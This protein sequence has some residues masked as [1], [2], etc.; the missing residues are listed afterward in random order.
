MG[1]RGRL[2]MGERERFAMGERGRWKRKTRK[3][4]RGAK[5]IIN[6]KRKDVYN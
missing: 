2:R 6:H 3:I 5:K 1:E 4:K